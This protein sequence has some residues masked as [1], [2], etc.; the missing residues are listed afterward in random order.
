MKKFVSLSGL[1]FLIACS[2]QANDTSPEKFNSQDSNY[3]IQLIRIGF[4]EFADTTKIDSLSSALTTRFDIYDDDINRTTHIDAEE[5]AEFSFDF[6]L[7]RLK[8]ILKLRGF[9][10]IVRTSDDYQETYDV[11]I[12]EEK[13]KLYAKE[14]MEHDNFWMVAS[15]AFFKE[16]NR[17]LKNS[18]LEES[19]YLLY[20]DNDLHAMLLTPDQCSL[21]RDKYRADPKE[22]PYEP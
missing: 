14:D 8:Q 16:I 3:G 20:E 22:Q 5:L 1:F 19:F 7:P 9:D 10:L 21:V 18:K 6:F 15:R 11:F 4:L 17:Q 13:V 12:N 2:Q